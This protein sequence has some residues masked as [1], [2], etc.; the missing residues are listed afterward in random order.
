MEIHAAGGGIGYTVRCTRESSR[1]ELEV[2]LKQRLDRMLTQG[3]TT[4]EAKSGYGLEFETELKM[5]QVLHNLD[6]THPID[7]VSNYCGAHSVP[8]GLTAAAYTE[9]LISEQLPAIM[10]EKKAGTINPQLMDVFCEKG[11]F[12]TEQSQRILEAGKAYGLEAN[13]HLEHVSAAGIQAMARA[14]TVAVLLPT[15]AYV[16]R[17]AMPPARALIDAGVAVALGSDFN[18]NAH[19][20]SLPFVMNL[21]CVQMRMTLNEAL[22]AATLNAAASLKRSVTHGSLEVGKFADFVVVGHPVWEH[23]IYELVDPPISQVFKNG[24]NV[25]A[26]TRFAS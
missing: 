18:P 3:T 11:V 13:F 21:A 25:F 1:A 19:C 7:I 23:I 17:I 14:G 9:A 15:T 10:A 26:Q 5:L 2:L 12:S 4:I 24:I 6:R 8:A 20:V 16:L 22:V